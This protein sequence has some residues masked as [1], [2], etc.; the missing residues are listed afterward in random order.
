M[1]LE[2]IKNSCQDFSRSDFLM[3][4]VGPVEAAINLTDY[5]S[6]TEPGSIAGVINVGLAGAY[7]D[8]DVNVL[9]ICLADHEFFGDIGICL[10]DRIDELAD[11][12]SPP[13]AFKLDQELLAKA[14]LRLGEA[15][16]KC[17]RGNFIT[18]SSVSGTVA[19]GNYL[20]DKFG[21][22]C[23]NMEGAA[24]ARVC[25]KF[26]LPC[27]EIRCVSNMVIDRED[28]LWSTKEAIDGCCLAVN[29]FLGD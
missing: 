14:E 17:K 10:Q 16:I 28:Q 4:G 15:G 19:R 1:E 13:L 25:R 9:E 18:V 12:F 11:S 23:E 24:I 22:I 26:S 2:A 7:P 5:L 21:A 6:R 29:A 8:T 20:R 27:L 3:S